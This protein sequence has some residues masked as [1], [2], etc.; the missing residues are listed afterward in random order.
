MAFV[1]RALATREQRHIKDCPRNW[2]YSVCWMLL[3]ILACYLAAVVRGSRGSMTHVYLQL[4]LC[5][6]RPLVSHIVK[7]TVVAI[8]IVT[9]AL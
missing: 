6:C 5:G 7:R 9:G 3:A 8:S 2:Y 4:L 1:L